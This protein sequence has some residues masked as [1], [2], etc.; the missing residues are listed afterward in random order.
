VPA[1]YCGIYQ[2]GEEYSG[3]PRF[4]QYLLQPS[5]SLSYFPHSQNTCY[6]FPSILLTFLILTIL[7]IAFPVSFL[8]SSFS[9]YLLQPSQSLPY[10]PHSHN[11]CYSL[12][13]L[14]LTF[15]LLKILAIAFPVFLLLS[16]FSKCL[17][18]PSQSL[19]YFPHSQYS[20]CSNHFLTFL[21]LTIPLE[22][23][24]FTVS[25]KTKFMK[26]PVP[27]ELDFSPFQASGFCSDITELLD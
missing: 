15:L 10:F 19:S 9:K 7:A 23:I 21:I 16:S 12:P 18:E 14:F 4:S 1:I 2:A 17:L 13:S 5:Q 24:V 20:T 11:T 8:L 22:S 6:S 26:I 27:V 3:L 25:Q